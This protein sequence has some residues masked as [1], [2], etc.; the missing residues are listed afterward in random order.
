MLTHLWPG[1]QEMGPMPEEAGT[2][3]DKNQP[4]EERKKGWSLVSMRKTQ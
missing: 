1:L 2:L 3:G 4:K